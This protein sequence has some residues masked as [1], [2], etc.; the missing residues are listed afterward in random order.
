M[1][2]QP[3]PDTIEPR[4]PPESPFSEPVERPMP[5]APEIEPTP[6]DRDF[7]DQAPLEDPASPY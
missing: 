6:P 4:S 3:P 7:P 1:A 2:T 5:N